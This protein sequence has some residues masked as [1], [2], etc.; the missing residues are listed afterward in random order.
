MMLTL[1]TQVRL[2]VEA[3]ITVVGESVGR[4]A[5]LRVPRPQRGLLLYLRK[6][7]HPADSA[8]GEMLWQGGS[9]VA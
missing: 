9:K 7:Y 3:D 4:C 8:S 2:L 5:L 1:R 6:A